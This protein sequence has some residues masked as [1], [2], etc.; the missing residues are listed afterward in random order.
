MDDYEVICTTGGHYAIVLRIEGKPFTKVVDG[1]VEVEPGAVVIWYNP[2]T[3]VLE[4]Y[5]V[6]FEFEHFKPS[7]GPGGGFDF[8]TSPEYMVKDDYFKS[9][10]YMPAYAEACRLWYEA[11]VKMEE[12]L[13]A[14]RKH[15]RQSN[16]KPK[17][18]GK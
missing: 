14:Y 13:K 11:T 10:P 1:F 16:H 3:N 5:Q 17:K 7:D 9:L 8:C 6:C 18:R 4:R 2:H 15:V 12:A